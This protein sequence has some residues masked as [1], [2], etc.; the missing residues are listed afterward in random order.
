MLLHSLG[1]VYG[2]HGRDDVEL[3]ECSRPATRA[4]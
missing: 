1:Q 4:I 2:N 3:G